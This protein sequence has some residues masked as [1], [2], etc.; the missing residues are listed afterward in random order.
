MHFAHALTAA[1]SRC[2]DK[3][4]IANFFSELTG[5]FDRFNNAI[6]TGYRRN[7]AALHGVTGGSLVTHSI[8]TLGRRADEHQIVVGASTSEIGVFSQEAV[9][10]VN[11]LTTGVHR[12][13]DDGRHY[14]IALICRSRTD[15]YLFIRVATGYVSASSVEYTATVLMPNSLQARI[16]RRATSPRLAIKTL[17]NIYALSGPTAS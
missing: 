4:R 6:R 17:S 7:A 13:S 1:A 8:N 10:R 11:S 9:T 3:H 5:L 16:M 2:L 14:Q 15:A 12:C